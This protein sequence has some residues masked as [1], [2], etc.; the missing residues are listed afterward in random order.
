V[1]HRTVSRDAPDCPVCQRSNDYFA[2]TVVCNRIECAIVRARVRAELDGASD[3]EQC[4]SGAPP[5]CPVAQKTD[6]PT[7]D[8]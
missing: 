6:A 4:L 5:D 1:K 3:T 2:P 8:P 7:V